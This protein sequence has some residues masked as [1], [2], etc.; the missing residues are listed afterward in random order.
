MELTP[1]ELLY[2]VLEREAILL[3]GGATAYDAR[4]QAIAEISERL[5]ENIR[6]EFLDATRAQQKTK[7][8]RPGGR[9][10]R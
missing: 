1:D 5:G 3:D 7:T 8:H 10:Y 2:E 6:W 9:G 4:Q